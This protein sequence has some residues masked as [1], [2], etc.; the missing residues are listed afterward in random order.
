[1]FAVLK[2]CSVPRPTVTYEVYEIRRMAMPPPPCIVLYAF[3]CFL[4]WCL[5]GPDGPDGPVCR[6]LLSSSVTSWLIFFAWWMSTC[7]L[8]SG[9]VCHTQQDFTFPPRLN[10]GHGLLAVASHTSVVPIT[11]CCALYRCVQD[12]F[13]V[14]PDVTTMGKVI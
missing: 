5:D 7:F 1:M 14:T 6:M 11:L 10:Y 2:W 4:G 9:K 3:V 8:R 12:Y 13:G